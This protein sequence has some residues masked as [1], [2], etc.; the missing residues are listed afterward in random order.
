M[1]DA[2]EIAKYF[3][4]HALFI[5]EKAGETDTQAEKDA[6]YILERL[7]STGETEIS[8]SSALD[9]CKK[10]GRRAEMQPG[11]DVLTERGYVVIDK[12]GTKGRPTEK[13]CFNPE[14]QKRNSLKR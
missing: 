13:I 8:I 6:K 10:F 11:L 12:R 9:L 2:I 7:Q 3:V 14:M 4:D 5:F 1:Q